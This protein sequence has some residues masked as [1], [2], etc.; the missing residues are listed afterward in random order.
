MSKRGLWIAGLL[1]GVVLSALALLLL[2]AFRDEQTKLVNHLEQQAQLQTLSALLVKELGYSGMIHQFKNFVIRGDEQ[3]YAAAR[4]AIERV[5]RFVFESRRFNRN[6][7]L[8]LE[9]QRIADMVAL[10]KS[11]LEMARLLHLE[12]I[13]VEQIDRQ[14]KVDD[15]Q[16][17]LALRAI[18]SFL[19]AELNQSTLQLRD[20]NKGMLRYL[21]GLIVSGV[22]IG[23]VLTLLLYYYFHFARHSRD[24][25]DAIEQRQRL[26]DAAPNPIMVV[27]QNGEI[28]FANEGAAQLFEVAKA[29]L[30]H[31]HLEHWIPGV[32]KLQH[33]RLRQLFFAT[34]GARTMIN[35]VQ[36]QTRSGLVRDVEVC[37]GLFEMED[38]IYA[39]ANILDVSRLASY[40]KRL[41]QAERKYRTTFEVAPVGIA[42]VDLEYHFID[43]NPCFALLLGYSTAELLGKTTFEITHPDDLES[44]E[45]ILQRLLADDLELFRAEKRYLRRDGHVVWVNLVVTLCRDS[46]GAPQYMIGV[47]EDITQRK[48]VEQH[49]LASEKRFRT[50]AQY[51]N[52]VVWMSTPGVGKMLF[53]NEAY[54]R[55]WQRS[56]ESLY[57]QPR[58]FIEAVVDEDRPRVIDELQRHAEGQWCI[59]YRIERPDGTLRHIQDE[60]TAVRGDD[61]EILYL[62][63]LARDI[64]DE[65]VVRERLENTN[66]QLER[67]AK[68]DPL[69]MALRRQYCVPDLEECLALF[70]RYQTDATLVFVDLDDFKSINDRLGHEAGDEVLMEF[71]RVVRGFIRETDAF[72][73]YAGDEFLIL[74]RETGYH[75]AERFIAKMLRSVASVQIG[76][77]Q[78]IGIRFSYGLL[79]LAEQPCES[80]RDWIRLA[81]ENM[82]E[83][84]RRTK[85][86]LADLN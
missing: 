77:G 86:Q 52:G 40:R 47:M 71:S 53:V 60:G 81:D 8:E 16:A 15:A 50:I 82:Y 72:Y 69:T 64:T 5:E 84:K 7:H 37:I 20:Y 73:R 58:S 9:Y 70:R 75:D 42:H 79:S 65:Q 30:Q 33:E 28:I 14:V 55:I 38:Q 11:R 54:E 35:P 31:S 78:S 32:A 61:N 21:A 80:A 23:T 57:S 44:S 45:H 63:G 34:K 51:V 22:L 67:L 39:V 46:L 68:F 62:V 17:T 41:D 48:L 85:E 29:E 4:A 2:Q 74:L 13:P 36:L 25:I 27:A 66:Q 6:S 3:Y 12:S 49:L 83:N 59:R 1:L 43:V 76:M 19:Q 56:R 26:L 10:Y 24:V 18:I